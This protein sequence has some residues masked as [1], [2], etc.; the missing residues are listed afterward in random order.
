MNISIDNL[1][2]KIDF[3]ATGIDEIIQN[4]K[5]ILTT[6]VGTVPFDRDFGIDWSLLDLPVREAKAK[7]TIEYA[8]KI[9]KYEPRVNI[10]EV[11]F[12]TNEHGQLKPRVVIEVVDA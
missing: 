10:K 11:A 2:L 9:R 12:L 6:P 4:I 1:D 8:E 3:S 5:T 7:L